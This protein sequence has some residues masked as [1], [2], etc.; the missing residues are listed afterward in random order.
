MQAQYGAA[1]DKRLSIVFRDMWSQWGFRKG[2]MRGFWITALREVP[3]YA[4]Y[5]FNLSPLSLFF[6]GFCIWMSVQV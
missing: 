2:V 1:S 4:G 3:A 6:P 5:V